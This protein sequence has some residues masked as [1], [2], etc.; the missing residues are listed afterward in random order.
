MRVALMLD[1]SKMLSM[2]ALYQNPARQSFSLSYFVSLYIKHD[3]YPNSNYSIQILPS[4]IVNRVFEYIPNACTVPSDWRLSIS[5]CIIKYCLFVFCI[6]CIYHCITCF[7][8]TRRLKKV[9][10]LAVFVTA[11]GA[12]CQGKYCGRRRKWEPCNEKW[13]HEVVLLH[14]LECTFS[15]SSGRKVKVFPLKVHLVTRDRRS[16][17]K[18]PFFFFFLTHNFDSRMY[19]VCTYS[20]MCGTM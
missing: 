13:P 8:T 4:Q 9:L 20:C 16:V 1:T 10:T 5:K 18:S 19:A 3:N 6:S 14:N 11:G 2:T 17:F 12:G 15:F 7:Q